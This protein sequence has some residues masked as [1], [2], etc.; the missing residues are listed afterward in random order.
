MLDL[1]YKTVLTVLNKNQRGKIRPLDFNKNVNQGTQKVY[2]DL[3]AQFKK[4]NL[5][6][7]KYQS[8]TNYGDEAG[9]VKQAMEHYISEQQIALTSMKEGDPTNIV[10]YPKDYMLVNSIFSGDSE[11]QKTDASVFNKLIRSKRMKPSVC[12]PIFSIKDRGIQVAPPVEYVD[13]VYFRKPKLAKWTYRFHNGVEMF[14]PSKADYQDL[15]IHPLMLDKL[16]IETLF[17]CG[18]NLRDR[19][20]HEYI[21]MMKSEEIQSSQ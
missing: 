9:Y 21:Q 2:G 14:D 12:S 13:F 15:D 20:I 1:F 16:F 19:E 11:F 8:T 3:F 5:R 6:K 4:L 7:A 17:L 10:K 18:V